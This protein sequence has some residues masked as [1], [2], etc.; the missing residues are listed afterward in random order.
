MPQRNVASNFTFEQQRVE[1]NNLAQDFW[2][3]KGTVDTALPTFLKH[4]GSNNFTGQTLAVPSAFTINS[5]SGNGTVTISGNLQ[6][7]G[8]TTTVN[9]ATMDVVDK[10]IT[11]AKGSANDAAADG[12]GITIDSA[13]DITFNFVD[14]KDALVSSIGLEATTFIKS[15]RAQFTG[16]GNP[17]TGQGL[18]L[19]APDQNTGQIASYDRDTP[20]YKELRLKGSTVSLYGGTTNAL[21][22]TFNST[23]LIIE[24]GKKIGVGTASPTNALDV[25]GGT[26]NT[27]IVAR[28]TDAKAA[29]SFVD[30]TT[31]GVGSVAVGAEGDDLFLTS[32]SGGAERIRIEDDGKIKFITNATSDYLQYGNNPRLWLKC[33]SGINGLRIDAS[34]TP[35][36]IKTS[37]NDG[38]SIAVDSNFNFSVNGDYSLSAGQYDSSGKIFL[39][40]TRHNGTNTSTAFQ[41]SIQAVA[42]ANTNNTGYLGFGASATPDDLV[43][44]TNGKV[45]IGITD[46]TTADLHVREGNSGAGIF[47]VGGATGG[48]TGLDIDYSNSGSTKTIIKQNY[49]AT[50]AGAELSFDSGFF[51]F[52]VG[53]T[54]NTEALRI[55]SSSILGA[56]SIPIA[57]TASN[58]VGNA[59]TFQ[60][61][62]VNTSGNNASAGK[63][64]SIAT[65]AFDGSTSTWDADL[66]FSS[67]LNSTENERLRIHSDGKVDVAGELAV[68]SSIGIN[69]SGGTAYP[70]HVYSGQKYL[71]GLKN[72]SANSGNGY[73]WLVHDERD[74]QSSLVIH[75]NGIGDRF[76]I[77]ENGVIEPN[78]DNSQNLGSTS[79][80]W[81]NVYTGDM[82][83]NNM[84]TGGN[85]VD[86]SE[87]HWTMQEGSDDL[88]LINRNTGK[89]YK[90]NLTEVS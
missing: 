85:E 64:Q 46:N 70:L 25:Q 14:A 30:N 57:V 67:V 3:Q 86:G 23:G 77:K 40:A 4:D 24:S 56:A 88:F 59:G 18:E 82:H 28:S 63:I 33:P 21:V 39:N 38:K 71:V 89:K 53:T 87:G 51:T 1:I 43:I 90:F 9:T 78:S 55:T 73:P 26:T 15:T 81:A 31:T 44:Q 62:H 48:S 27:A 45:G 12:A 61:Y 16:A 52:M 34:T 69:G 65:G 76:V 75:F 79:K 17:T 13:T 32:G 36:E 72:S 50:N 7:D 74:G 42:T 11:I 49:R 20:A 2:S 58:G 66:V 80:R 19:T 83:L 8:T 35:L 47:R 84:N 37:N 68:G 6:V 10:N 5:D 54:G 22:G 29:I 41:T 60:F